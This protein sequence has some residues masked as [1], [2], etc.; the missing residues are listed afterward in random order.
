MESGIYTDIRVLHHAKE[1]KSGFQ[2]G[3]WMGRPPELFRFR[4][5]RFR[6]Q[7]LCHV[8]RSEGAV[9]RVGDGL[10]RAYALKSHRVQ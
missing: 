10:L 6:F 3:K 2:D 5:K 4:L 8:E 9:K 1:K 7:S